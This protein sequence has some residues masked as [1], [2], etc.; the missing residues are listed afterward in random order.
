[1]D[2]VEEEEKKM[3]KE[4]IEEFDISLWIESQTEGYEKRGKK[5]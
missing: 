4:K 3:D 2:E 1:M 5:R